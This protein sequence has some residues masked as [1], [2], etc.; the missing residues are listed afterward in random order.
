MTHS[1]LSH[2]AR[3]FLLL[4][5]FA[6]PASPG[7]EALELQDSGLQ[8]KLARELRRLPAAA[9]ADLAVPAT[10]VWILAVIALFLAANT[11][12]LLLASIVRRIWRE[13]GQR[14]RDRFRS[15]WEP[16]L[17]ARMA[18]DT[19]SLPPL[20]AS[21]RLLFLNLWLHLL[22]Y[23]RD[24]AADA[25]VRT[26]HEL[27]LAQYA[28]YLL[29]HGSP[30][31]R[32]IAMR[33][34]AA[35]RLDEACDTLAAKAL[36]N[37]PRSSLEAARALLQI[38][39]ERGFAALDHLLDQQEWSPSAMAAIVQAGGSRT[40]QKLAARV[41]AAPPGRAK[42]LVRLI[43]LLE[44]Q[45]ALPALR[46]RLAF[47]RDEEELAAILHC[48]GR[49]GGSEDRDLALGY[50]EHASWLVRM[51]AAYALGAIGLAQDSGRLAPLL[52]DR[53]WWVR[54]R[55]AQSLLRLAGTA[56]LA[57]MR[58]GESDPYA[59]DMLERVLAEAR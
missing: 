19:L 24:Q 51:Q 21:E 48:L 11:A 13:L 50:L 14:R 37:R 33:A 31:K 25:L 54:Y 22:G 6:A 49:L 10:P 46:A 47:S 41:Q 8:L 27:G 1:W 40:M 57:H 42:Q 12:L 29:E 17:Y 26:A 34:V 56:A 53:Q 28:L 52:R 44:D 20:A 9:G 39:P 36:E 45:S 35:L 58:E 5:L 16:V 7:A 59:R 55:T 23:V 38:E 32:L 4:A 2:A 18:G 3:L 15:R 30:W 43:E